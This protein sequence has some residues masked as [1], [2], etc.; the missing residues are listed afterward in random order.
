MNTKYSDGTTVTAG[1]S[2]ALPIKWLITGGCGFIGT[3][4][5]QNLVREGGHQ[6]RVVDNL[7]V[8]SLGDLGRV[9]RFHTVAD[10]ARET[11]VALPNDDHPSVELVV[12]DIADEQLAINAAKDVHVIVHLAANTGVEPSV[13]NPRSDCLTNVIGTLNYLEAARLQGVG[14]FVFASSCAPVGDCTPPMHEELAPHP[15]SPYGASKLAGEGYCSAFYR[16]FGVETVTL[17]F[18][19]VYGPLSGHKNSVVAKF[20]RQAMDHEPLQIYGDGRQTRDFIFVADLVNAIRQA[21]ALSGIAGETFQVATNAETTISELVELLLPI[22]ERH[23]FPR[24][25]VAHGASRLGDV[26]RNYSDTSKARRLLQWSA[27]VALKDGLHHTVQWF[28][29]QQQAAT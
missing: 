2:R 29:D 14:R 10:V 15:V 7:S 21:A 20:I 26:L 25:T 11:L 5:I 9:C 12:G 19:N 17:R 27:K 24:V 13:K 16:T 18:G 23:G 22:L 8:G 6:I 28:I 3:S 1:T 4:L